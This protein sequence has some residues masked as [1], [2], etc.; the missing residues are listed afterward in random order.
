MITLPCKAY[1]GNRKKMD[2][3]QVAEICRPLIRNCCKA[4]GYTYQQIRASETRDSQMIRTRMALAHVIIAA[5]IT[6][7][8]AADAAGMSYHT[9]QWSHWRARGLYESNQDFR[10]LCNAIAGNVQG[11][12]PGEKE[13]ANE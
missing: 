2:P 5:G 8:N 6:C 10:D 1:R 7:Q 11:H 12:A 9:A 13:T 3:A 4:T